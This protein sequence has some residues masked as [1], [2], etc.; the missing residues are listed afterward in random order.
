MPYKPK[1]PCN[2]M[3]C[4]ATTTERY[5]EQHTKEQRKA[6]DKGRES[7]YK[8]GYGRA[9]QKLRLVVLAEEPLCRMCNVEGKVTAAEH[10]D[11]IDGDS[12]NNNRE[13]LR[14]LCASCH[15][16]R[17]ARDQAFG[18]KWKHHIVDVNKMV[19]E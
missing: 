6:I 2:K 15:N 18:R 5:C 11:H 13:N 8:R 10:V 9:W 4:G 17:T 12:F 7:S 1:R 19:E 14:P 16:S 3:G